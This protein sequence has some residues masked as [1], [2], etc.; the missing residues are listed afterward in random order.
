MTA[1]RLLVIDDERDF[2]DFV[3]TVAEGLG[4]D[5]ETCTNGTDALDR[6]DATRPDLVVLDVVMPDVEGIQIVQQ[7]A[8]RNTAS[9]V[10]MVT[11]YDPGY[12]EAARTIG[13]AR[14]LRRI[15]TLTKPVRVEDL[16]ALLRAA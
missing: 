5:V 14:G 2:C 3:R 11:G 8:D 4:F 12:V 16:R 1:K 9:R 6:F 13:T 10:V 7:L 15:D